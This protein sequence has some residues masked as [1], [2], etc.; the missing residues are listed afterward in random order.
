MKT[1]K[2]PTSVAPAARMSSRRLCR[3]AV[4]MRTVSG[5][6]SP[7]ATTVRLGIGV[8]DPTLARGLASRSWPRAKVALRQPLKVGCD[9]RL[10]EFPSA[11]WTVMV[12]AHDT[13]CCLAWRLKLAAA[14]AAVA[15]PLTVACEALGQYL[16][17]LSDVEAR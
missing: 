16:S 7:A 11:E 4:I 2:S 13:G 5:W 12:V 15:R 8:S 1:Q 17:L 10:S 3:A 6:L 14:L 9:A